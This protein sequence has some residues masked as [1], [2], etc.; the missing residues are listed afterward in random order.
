MAKVLIL[1]DDADIRNVLAL[2]LE[3]SHKV[4]T[5]DNPGTWQ[6]EIQ[7]FN[8]DVILIDIRLGNLDG[9][10]I[11]KKLK[12]MPHTR[13]IKVI[14]TSAALYDMKHLEQ[15]SDGFLEKPFNIATVENLINRVC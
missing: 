8:P 4:V 3:A 2:I 13:H 11:C 14:L 7:D 5:V 9:I 10:V 15:I 1:D 12:S 6:Q